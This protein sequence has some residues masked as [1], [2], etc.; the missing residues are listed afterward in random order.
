[1]IGQ[2]RSPMVT[3]EE[4]KRAYKV[5]K[6]RLKLTRLD[7][8]SRLGRSPLTG[9][10]DGTIES[11][12]LPREFHQEVWDELVKRGQIHPDGDGFY[13]LGTF[14]GGMS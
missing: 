10:G 7:D 1:M 6:K 8:E 11:I 13:R 14:K 5:F 9:G 2:Q 3:D 12:T 4:L